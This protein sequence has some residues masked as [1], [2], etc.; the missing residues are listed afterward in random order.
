MRTWKLTAGVVAIAAVATLVVQAQGRGGRGGSQVGSGEP[1]PPGTTLVR[2]GN[3]QAPQTPAP[4][5]LDYRPEST[6]VAPAHPTPKAKYPAID[7]HGHPGGRLSSA[8]GLK[9]MFAELDALNV[10]LMLSAENASG[11]RLKQMVTTAKASPYA[12][13]EAFFTGVSC[14]N[15]GP[16][17][18]EH[19]SAE[20]EADVAAGAVGVGGAGGGEGEVG[21]R[22]GEGDDPPR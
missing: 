10:G 2:P 5:I 7:F 4:S 11:D 15:D 8:E 14:A 3:C 16:G 13:R 19:V 22:E 21:G 17:W 1:C 12:T 6:L 18:A 20:L 9:T